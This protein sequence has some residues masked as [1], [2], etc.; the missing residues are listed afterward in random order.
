MVGIYLLLK[1]STLILTIFR[2]YLEETVN[3]V[4]PISVQLLLTK[5]REVLAFRKILDTM[6]ITATF[7]P[8]VGTKILS[9]VIDTV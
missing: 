2:L 5:N 8:L 3:F 9:L 4:I 7:Y 1:S 6:G